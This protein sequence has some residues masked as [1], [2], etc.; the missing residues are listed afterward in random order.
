MKIRFLTLFPEVI[1]PYIAASIPGRA[2]HKE[3]VDIRVHNIRDWTQDRHGRVDDY[4]FGGGAG[5]V[6][7]PQPLFDSIDA[8]RAQMPEGTRVVY[9]SPCGVPFD[10]RLARELAALPGLLLVCGH[11]EG[12]D[13]RVIDHRVDIEISIGDYVLT[14]GELP[15][16]IVMDA[17]LRFIPGVVGNE[18]VHDEESF[19]RGLLEYPQYTR[20][21]VFRGIPVPEVLLSGH[22]A[23]IAAWQRRQSLIR[24]ASVRPDLIKGA[25]LTQAEREE[26]ASARD[27]ST[28][29]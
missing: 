13:Q 10:N 14:G 29:E 7:T 16:L 1:E 24:T 26:I 6:M 27:E 15:A 22:H 25:Q 9:P 18:C 20:P 17:V 3:L 5:M 28:A 23:H 2:R 12:I 11:Y 19:E 4:P 8:V 21:A